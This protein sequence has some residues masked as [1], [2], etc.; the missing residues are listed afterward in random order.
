MFYE[1]MRIS[2]DTFMT[3]MRMAQR[4]KQGHVFEDFL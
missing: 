3:D 2:D 4:H 1:R